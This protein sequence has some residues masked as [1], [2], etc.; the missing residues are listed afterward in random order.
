MLLRVRLSSVPLSTGA[1]QSI[2]SDCVPER[3]G[4]R[5]GNIVFSSRV[6]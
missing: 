5:G 4:Q 1:P 3:L 6:C 2:S